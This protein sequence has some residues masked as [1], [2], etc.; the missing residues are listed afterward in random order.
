MSA[1]EVQPQGGGRKKLT[2]WIVGIGVAL[3][4]SLTALALVLFGVIPGIGGGSGEG[5]AQIEGAEE[6]GAAA[7][8]VA[9]LVNPSSL[10]TPIK[11]GAPIP[12]LPAASPAVNGTTPG[13]YG[14]S[15]TETCNPGQLMSFLGQNP[16]KAAAWV[17]ALNADP[18]LRWG[19]GQPLTIAEIPIFVDNLI[20]TVLQAD[21]WV[22]NH[23]F[24]GN[25]ATPFQS[26]LQRGTAVLVDR[27]GVPRA[28]CLC[29]NP[30]LPAK[31]D[32]PTKPTGDPWEGFGEV[33]PQ[34]IEPNPEPVDQ[35][36]VVDPDGK[37]VVVTS[38]FCDRARQATPDAACPAPGPDNATVV[39]DPGQAAT[40]GNSGTSQTPAGGY[41]K[42]NP[43]TPSTDLCAAHMGNAIAISN[44]TEIDFNISNNSPVEVDLWVPVFT[45]SGEQYSGIIDSCTMQYVE[46]LPV[47]AT[48]VYHSWSDIPWY[49]VESQQGTGPVATTINDGSDWSIA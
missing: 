15:G 3:V 36:E 17:A 14:G 6:P 12:A 49:A 29:G 31:P 19:T 33:P 35:L 2:G 44:P 47:G 37:L 10:I 21:T 30:L 27:Y 46:T 32:L 45:W 18:N 42:D 43:V 23:G 11:K 16:V 8:M 5:G 1:T 28:R 40:P 4:A 39:G 25:R 26:L 41:V 13:L 7:F 20:P 22:T 38:P 48:D 34:Q 24:D 9:D